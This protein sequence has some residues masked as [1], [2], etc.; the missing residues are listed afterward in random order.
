[1]RLAQGPARKA[2]PEAPPWDIGFAD[3]VT[4]LNLVAGV[5]ATYEAMLG[6][7]TLATILV[8]AAMAFDFLDGKV[9]RL[10]KQEH[11]L[12]RELD[13]LADMVSFGVAP[14]IILLQLYGFGVLIL[15]AAAVYAVAGAL[16]LARFNL[17][18]AAGEKGYFLGVPIP[19]AAFLLL[20]SSFLGLAAWL[21]ALVMAALAA[22]MVSDLRIQ[23]P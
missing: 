21:Q 4:A 19:A 9:A 22:L 3:V 16:R 11:A 10:L 8:A 14:S 20:A 18:A 15:A 2:P 1:M 23:K 12:G 6:R 5:F 7:T 13:S 17:L